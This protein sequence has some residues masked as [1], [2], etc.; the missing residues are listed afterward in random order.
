MNRKHKTN[1]EKELRALFTRRDELFALRKAQPL[2]QLDEPYQKGWLVYVSLRDD[3][4]NTKDAA[5][6]LK[7]IKKGFKP[8][9]Y[10]R[11]V[12][13]VRYIRK[14]IYGEIP[15]EYRRYPHN[16]YFPTRIKF[17]QEQVDNM[18]ERERKYFMRRR[19]NSW[20]RYLKNDGFYLHLP[21]YW[22]KLKTKPNMVTESRLINSEIESEYQKIWNKITAMDGWNKFYAGSYNWMYKYKRHLNK[23]VTQEEKDI[24]FDSWNES[25]ENLD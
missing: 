14:G 19:K 24:S 7:L 3:I 9:H 12:K 18:T 25:D 23:E 10:I 13:D 21:K 1:K 16:G 20:D 17:S 11:K 22:Y 15:Y 8:T 5:F 4:L 6:F 2:V